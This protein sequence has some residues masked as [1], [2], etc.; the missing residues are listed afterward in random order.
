VV[1]SIEAQGF[2][3]TSQ[4]TSSDARSTATQSTL[5]IVRAAVVV[6]TAAFAEPKAILQPIPATH[7]AFAEVPVAVHDLEHSA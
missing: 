4:A 5:D 1:R 2:L 6:A 7:K 3:S